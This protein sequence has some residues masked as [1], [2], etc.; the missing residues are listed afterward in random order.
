MSPYYGSP[1]TK[2]YNMIKVI[3]KIMYPY[4]LGLY[5][6]TENRSTPNFCPLF[7]GPRKGEVWCTYL[8]IGMSVRIRVEGGEPNEIMQQKKKPNL[9]CRMFIQFLDERELEHY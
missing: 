3:V 1:T 4:S 7:S 9:Y 6:E 2:N 5:F 8:D